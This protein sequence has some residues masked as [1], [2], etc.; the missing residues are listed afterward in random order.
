VLGIVSCPQDPWDKCALFENPGLHQVKLRF[1][2]GFGAIHINSCD[3]IAEGRIRAELSLHEQS[4]ALAA[5]FYWRAEMEK[6]NVLSELIYEYY[7]SRICFGIY[8]YGDQLKSVSQ[9]CASFGLARNTVQTALNKLEEK[10]YIKTEQRRMARVIYQGTQK[11]FKENAG[12][13]FVPRR[14]GLRDINQWGPILFS[15]VWEKGIKR[16]EQSSPDSMYVKQDLIMFEA[17]KLYCWIH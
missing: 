1:L 5:I 4:G 3:A 15:P 10:G 12:K 11:I 6:E 7:Q 13:H 14:D 17:T 16:F 9:L 8:K 2:I